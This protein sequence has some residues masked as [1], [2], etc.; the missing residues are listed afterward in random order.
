MTKVLTRSTFFKP[1]PVLRGFVSF[2]TSPHALRL[3]EGQRSSQRTEDPHKRGRKQGFCTQASGTHHQDQVVQVGGGLS[4]KC[5]GLVEIAPAER[6]AG[7]RVRGSEAELVCV[8]ARVCLRMCLNVCVCVCVRV[9]VSERERE[10]E[11]ER[12]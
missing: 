3:T 1:K 7:A 11:R 12:I 10:R 6:R 5:F 4:L 2:V 8:G 9:C